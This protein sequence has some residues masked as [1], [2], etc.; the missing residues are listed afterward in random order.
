MK[1]LF[2]GFGCGL[3]ILLAAIL[4]VTPNYTEGAGYVN[5]NYGY[6]YN[7]NQVQYHQQY[8]VNPVVVIGVPVSNLGVPYY[9]SVG[10]ELRE[11]RIAERAANLVKN[12]QG[13][14]TKQERTNGR[15]VSTQPQQPSPGVILDFDLVSAAASVSAPVQSPVGVSDLDAQ[16]KAI[17]AESCIRCHKPGSARPGLQLLNADGSLF[18]ERDWKAELQRRE[19]V[20]DSV[21][22]TEGV[23]PM[24]KNAEQLADDKIELIYLWLREHSQR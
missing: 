22:G 18:K 1:R 6:G 3:L 8:A 17:F 7:Y 4:L 21:R 5:T 15:P 24:P 10:Q 19:A 14:V 12:K 11:E 9:W 20:Y 2:W 13:N 23:S 16:V